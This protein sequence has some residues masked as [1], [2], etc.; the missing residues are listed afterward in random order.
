MGSL[1]T[2]ALD[3]PLTFISSLNLPDNPDAPAL[4]S[5]R[6]R[7]RCLND[8]SESDAGLMDPRGCR[9]QACRVHAAQFQ[10]GPP[11]QATMRTP[12]TIKLTLAVRSGTKPPVG[13][14]PSQ[15]GL[16]H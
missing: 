15:C 9:V 12:R 4:R 3:K 14:A 13:M 7:C 16:S 11:P 10:A 5:S 1:R 2:T 8:V 6:Y